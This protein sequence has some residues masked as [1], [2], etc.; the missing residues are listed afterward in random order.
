[1]KLTI[2]LEKVHA[3]V[4]CSQ[5]ILSLQTFMPEKNKIHEVN[6]QRQ[7]IIIYFL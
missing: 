3:R 4:D 1:L 7:T 6:M 2:V 5:E